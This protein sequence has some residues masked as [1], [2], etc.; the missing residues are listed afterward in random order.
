MKE[1]HVGNQDPRIPSTGQW[2]YD[3]SPLASCSCAQYFPPAPS[4]FC[5]CF[6]N[7]PALPPFFSFSHFTPSCRSVLQCKIKK[8]LI[9]PGQLA[10]WQI[11]LPYYLDNTRTA[12]PP[13]KSIRAC[14]YLA[15]LLLFFFLA[16]RS[17]KFTSNPKIRRISRCSKL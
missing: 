13:S 11:Q 16:K 8:E 14:S 10:D 3:P 6:S 1:I 7:L 5:A 2:S 9:S 4:Q 15:F 17:W 12:F